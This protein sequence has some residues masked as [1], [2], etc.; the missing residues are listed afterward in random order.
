MTPEQP[1]TGTDREGSLW[2]GAAHGPL[3][4]L[5][6]LLTVGTGLVDAVSVLGLGRVFVA[7]MTGNVVFLGFAV[8]GA[9]GF[10]LAAS[11]A[12]LGGI[13][14]GAL[15]GGRL[16]AAR[17][18][19]RGRLLRDAVLVELI[20]VIVV[21][22]LLAPLDGP[23]GTGTASV[24]AGLLA[25]ALGLQNAAVRRLGVPDLTTT[26]LTMTLTGIAA[27]ERSGGPRVLTRRVL[28]V[29][30]M[31]A[32]AVVGAVLVD[33][34]RLVWALSPVP[35]LLAVVAVVLTVTLRRPTAWQGPSRP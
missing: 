25:A 22:V 30:A 32:G 14:V 23:P 8:A 24:V 34:G 29:V 26:V 31:F 7:N 18:S 3:P 20:V 21:L 1:A 17:T 28:A 16:V 6:L 13:L 15:G 19:G 10:A 35:V 2:R 11:L 4:A 33:Q 27:D 9:P 5:L 12:A